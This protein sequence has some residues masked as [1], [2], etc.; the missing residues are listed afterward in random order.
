MVEGTLQTQASPVDLKRGMN[1]TTASGLWTYGGG[2][3]FAALG[4]LLFTIYLF[5]H[6][7]DNPNDQGKTIGLGIFLLLWV[8]SLGLFAVAAIMLGLGLLSG[9]GP[10]AAA[11]WVMAFGIMQVAMAVL[12]IYS[13]SVNSLPGGNVV[14]PAVLYLLGGGLVIAASV[15]GRVPIA[16]QRFLGAGLGGGGALLTLIAG[17]MIHSQIGG[18]G[19]FFGVSSITNLMFLGIVEG[20]ALLLVATAVILHTALNRS[21]TRVTAFLALGVA[22]VIL[23]LT[24]FIQTMDML[25]KNPFGALDFID[26]QLPKT[27]L[28]LAI[29]GSI[30]IGIAGLVAIAAAV[31]TF[32]FYGKQ[33][34]ALAPRPAPGWT[35]MGA[36]PPM[37]APPAPA[38]SAGRAPAGYV[39]CPQC[40]SPNPRG[41]K[42]CNNCGYAPGGM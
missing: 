41:A 22:A 29:I 36:A 39:L 2:A 26:D 1:L 17:Q 8:V 13:A 18:A 11:N 31:L 9:R 37:A 14:A 21:P 38:R 32:V 10:A 42:F 33:L 30:V 16:Q 7:G 19:A 24:Y 3:L 20:L 27:G 6:A 15:I 5:S 23:G 4:I 25:G 35:D 12:L 34:S 40:R 28:M